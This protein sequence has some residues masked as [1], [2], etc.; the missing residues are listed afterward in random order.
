MKWIISLCVG[1]RAN[2]G[3]PGIFIEDIFA[4]N[5]C[6]MTPFL[7]MTRLWI[8]GDSDDVPLLGYIGGHLPD[9]LAYRFSPIDFTI[10][11]VLRNTRN[12]VL[13]VVPTPDPFSRFENYN[14]IVAIFIAQR[15]PCL[16]IRF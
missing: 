6:W 10:F 8:K 13:K 1:N 5:E 2:N 16:P 15:D 11:V 3:H 7:L 12:Q 14:I 4:D 9:L